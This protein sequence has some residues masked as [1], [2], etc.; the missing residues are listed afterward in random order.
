[1]SS[2]MLKIKLPK[3]NY[4]KF[5]QIRD[6]IQLYAQLLSKLKSNTIPPQKNWEEHSLKAY[7]KGFTTGPMPVETA[8]GIEALDININLVENNLKLIFGTNRDTIDLHQNN[9]ASFTQIFSEKLFNYGITNFKPEGN[10]YLKENLIYDKEEA[11][12]LWDLLRQFYFIL[13]KFRGS[14]LYETSNVNLWPHHFD[15]ALLFFS[16]KLIEG[17]DRQ[18][19]DR[20]REQMNFGLSTGDKGIERPYFYITAYPFDNKLFDFKLPDYAHWHKEDWN[21]VVIHYDDMIRTKGFGY[22]LTEF[23]LNFLNT[24]FR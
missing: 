3:I 24:N 20:S 22:S 23:M 13:L 14:T 11:K 5:S 2:K 7:A 12:K 10:F 15:L 9:I 6:T 18:D 4:M 8:D 17:Q 21:G 1:M 16:G 19:W